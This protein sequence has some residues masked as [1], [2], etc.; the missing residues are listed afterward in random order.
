LMVGAALGPTHLIGDFLH[1]H[2]MK[3]QFK[4]LVPDE[5]AH[6]MNV[7]LMV[8]SS[9]VGLLG[10]A[11]AY[12]M[13]VKKRSLPDLIAQRLPLAYELSLNKF[14]LDEFYGALLVT[15][16]TMLSHV[17]R[18]FDAYIVDGLVDLIGQIP[19]LIGYLFRPIQNGLV[20]FYALLMALGLAGFVL[21]V[22]LR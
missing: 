3:E 13:Y 22:L 15:P 21:S 7:M 8:G 9:L 11:M 17:L 14:Y 12:L 10:I 1:N 5:P 18:V 19:A 4:S 2:W 16:L 6:H 20:Q